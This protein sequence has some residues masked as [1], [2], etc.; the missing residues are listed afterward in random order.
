MLA[1]K[2]PTRVRGIAGGSRAADD[3]SGSRFPAEWAR[4]TTRFGPTSAPDLR[5]EVSKKQADRAGAIL[6]EL[7]AAELRQWNLPS[8]QRSRRRQAGWTLEL[9][10]RPRLIQRSA[11]PRD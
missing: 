10:T 1:G 7:P 6:E 11:V 9:A 5:R 3:T 4:R 2:P 8:V